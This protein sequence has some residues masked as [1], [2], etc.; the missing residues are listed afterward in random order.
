MGRKPRRLLGLLKL[1]QDRKVGL[2]AG[3]IHSLT[4]FADRVVS[5]ILSHSDPAGSNAILSL[6]LSSGRVEVWIS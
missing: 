6:E 4:L 5:W 1:G 3:S 2:K